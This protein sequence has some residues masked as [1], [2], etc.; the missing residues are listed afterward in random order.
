MRALVLANVAQEGVRPRIARRSLAL[1]LAV[2]LALPAL[3]GSLRPGTAHA[4]ESVIAGFFNNS[5]YP[6]VSLTV[7]NQRL[8]DKSTKIARKVKGVKQVVNNITIKERSAGK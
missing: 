4:A 3:S 5:E 1:G 7:D 8:K 2:L 6:I